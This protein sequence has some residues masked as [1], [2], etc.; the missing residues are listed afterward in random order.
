MT[1]RISWSGIQRY[2]KCHQKSL[3][4]NTGR[5][6]KVQDTRIFLEGTVADR[7]MRQWLNSDDPQP[8]QMVGMVDEV[9]ERITSPESND[10][11]RRLIRW[12]GNPS[13]DKLKA[14]NFIRDVVNDL[15]PILWSM[16]IP[17]LFQPE[18]KFRTQIVIPYLDGRLTAVELIGGIDIVMQTQDE[19]LELP[20][21]TLLAPGD[22]A[23][24]DLKATRQDD[25]IAKTLGQGTFY[26]IAWGAYI[27]DAIQPRAFG[28]IAPALKNKVHWSEI[29]DA[30]RR[31]MMTRVVDYAHGHW[32]K[33]W[34][35]NVTSQCSNC[36]VKHACSAFGFV[37]AIDAAGKNRASFTK[38][39]K[40][41]AVHRPS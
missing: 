12:R 4:V 40:S 10:E 31:V 21:G 37:P 6:S 35:P 33:D 25:Y 14:K 38:T 2:E 17:H 41:R 30:D 13:S 27:G 18:L 24:F 11:D 28:F 34:T 5:S 32:R 9:F 23:L 7:I 39:A 20:N 16:V 29:T 26:D 3:L 22:F 8:G 1:L 36:E 15:E 19:E